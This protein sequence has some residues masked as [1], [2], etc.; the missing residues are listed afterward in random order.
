LFLA[1]RNRGKVLEV[2]CGNGS[3][4]YSLRGCFEELCGVELSSLRADVARRLLMGVEVSVDIRNGDVEEG[5][6]WPDGY[7]DV[8]ISADVIEHVVDI[9]T[10]A[11]EMAR[12]LRP[13]GTLICS[14]P[15]IAYLPRR[16]A[17]LL[18]KFPATAGS[19]EGF[20][21]R[22]GELYDGGHLHYFTFSTLERLF[23][24]NGIRTIQKLGFGRLGRLHN[25]YPQ[26]FSGAACIV[27]RK[28]KT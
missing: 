26:L 8:V 4:L 1:R 13:G 12:L 3:V 23:A 16:L 9:W 10:A 7:F 20:G 15:N 27:G 19:D 2:G 22:D 24:L 18:G 25:L 5:L 21:V 14:T 28:Q 11:S 6:E 17:L